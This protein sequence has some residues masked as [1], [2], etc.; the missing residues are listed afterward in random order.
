MKRLETMAQIL[1]FHHLRQLLAVVVEAITPQIQAGLVEA[2]VYK[3]AVLAQAEQQA[4]DLLVETLE[5]A[6]T[7]TEQVVVAV[8]ALLAE[9]AVLIPL[10]TVEPE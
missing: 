3:E 7:V 1:Y 9:T 6:Q 10:E 8:L 2:V 5:A 4:K